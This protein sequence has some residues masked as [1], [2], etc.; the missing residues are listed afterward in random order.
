MTGYYQQ[1]VLRTAQAILSGA[2]IGAFLKY[3]PTSL[4][5]RIVVDVEGLLRCACKVV[6]AV[7]DMSDVPRD[8]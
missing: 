1:D 8:A 3:D 2:P 4:S 7:D 5:E 6:D